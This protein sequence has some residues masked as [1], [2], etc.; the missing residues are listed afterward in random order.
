[1]V[2]EGIWSRS[3]YRTIALAVVWK[4]SGSRTDLQAMGRVKRGL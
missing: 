3:V 4:V 1:M 2:D